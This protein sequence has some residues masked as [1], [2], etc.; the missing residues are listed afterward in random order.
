MIYNFNLKSGIIL[1]SFIIFVCNQKLLAQNINS[2]IQDLKY[3][4][5]EI[6]VRAIENIA[7]LK[8][9]EYINLIIDSLKDPDPEVRIAAANGLLTMNAKES[10]SELINALNDT[11][12]RVCSAIRNVLIKFNMKDI[13]QKNLIENPNPQVREQIA[14]IL[15]EMGDKTD[16]PFLIRA[17]NDNDFVRFSAIKSLGKIGDESCVRNLINV[18]DDTL[19]EI[20]IEAAHSIMNIESHNS[21]TEI[22][23]LLDDRDPYVRKEV[24]PILD[25]MISKETY[26]FFI[27]SLMK[28]KSPNIRI[29]SAKALGILGD[30]SAIPVLITS[31]KDKNE[32]VR[33]EIF[34]SLSILIDKTAVFNIC[35]VLNDKDK[36]IREY[37]INSLSNLGDPKCIPFLIDRLSIEKDNQLLNLIYKTIIKISDRSVSNFLSNGLKNRNRY[38]RLCSV[39]SINKLKLNE[40]LPELLSTY[41]AEKDIDIKFTILNTLKEIGN[42]SILPELHEILISEKN[43]DL[44]IGIIGVL[45]VIGDYTS[46][47]ALLEC[48]KI[49][50]DI[51][52][53]ETE[54]LLDRLSDANSVEYFKQA[55]SDKNIVVR[56]YAIKILKKYPVKSMLPFVLS[57]TRDKDT[58]IRRDA[59]E[60]LGTI[61]DLSA[62]DELV[63]AL[64]DKEEEVRT[65][66]VKS[67]SKLGD[68]SVV[69]YVIPKLRD[70][71]ANVRLETVKLLKQYGN[72][73]ILKPIIKMLSK[74]Y[75]LNIRIEIVEIIE[76]FKDKESIPILIK[77]ATKDPEPSVRAI[78]VRTLGVIGD[79]YV[80]EPIK[81]IFRDDYNT[82]VKIEAVRSLAKLRVKEMIPEF[83]KLLS[84][85]NKELTDSIKESLDILIDESDSSY[86]FT[87]L[88]SENEQIKDYSISSLRKIKPKNILDNLF[89]LVKST[90][91]NTRKQI[92]SL[93]DD[94][95]D[96]SSVSEFLNL[97]DNP[98]TNDDIELLLWIISSLG[99]LR[100]RESIEFLLLTLKHRNSGIRENTIIALGQIGDLRA[101]KPLEYIAEN[102]VSM[103]VRNVAKTV[104]GNIS[105][106]R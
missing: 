83:V 72:E 33:A 68:P 81:K 85:D 1:F 17:L 66:A 73:E 46:I 63:R 19:C 27:E 6:R 93:I 100:S 42:K 4:T 40:L 53:M 15:G 21:I 98:S 29:Y 48:L 26:L 49:G 38:V 43:M 82:Q 37:V 89:A 47:P 94:I 35:F 9:N 41:R 91:G 87:C 76:K 105:K 5:S 28:N 8:N 34:K 11:D 103:T 71:S 78:C 74:E 58:Y 51:L 60:V 106:F 3:G 90:K 102:D 54:E 52:T 12:K 31:L 57:V 30:K 104:L 86:L 64:N 20:K 18:L 80:I 2:Y 36:K 14:V 16:I 77:T 95:A 97:V 96:D 70:K 65:E 45:K 10:V 101:K 13:L 88:Q 56:A 39:E 67:L 32:E 92:M 61:G 24:E 79:N 25:R 44:K 69:K 7:K 62:V 84:S 59:I 23:K 55:F 99:R 50:N 75:E 22:I